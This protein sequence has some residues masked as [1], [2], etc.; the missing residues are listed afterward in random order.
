M[1]QCTWVH[2]LKLGGDFKEILS[3]EEEEIPSI[4]DEEILIIERSQEIDL[5]I[6]DMDQDMNATNNLGN[7]R[8]QP[9][10]INHDHRMVLEHQH[11]LDALLASVNPALRIPRR[12]RRLRD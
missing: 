6:R 4:E 10:V 12:V 9:G 8:T 1:K 7:E 5:W 11:F 2:L 3:I